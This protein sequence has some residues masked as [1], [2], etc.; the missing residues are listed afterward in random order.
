MCQHHGQK[1][2]KCAFNLVCLSFPSRILVSIS[3]SAGVS[4]VCVQTASFMWVYDSL[5]RYK[6]YTSSNIKSVRSNQELWSQPYCHNFPSG[7]KW[8]S[9]KRKQTMPKKSKVS[10]YGWMLQVLST[11]VYC[12]CCE[13]ELRVII[14]RNLHPLVW[15]CHCPP[16]EYLLTVS[17]SLFLLFVQQTPVQDDNNNK[18]PAD[19]AKGK[20]GKAGKKSNPDEKAKAGAGKKGKKQ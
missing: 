14:C 2:E 17:V 8:Q 18:K 4:R 9:S 7:R 6:F 5:I 11:A 15:R 10:S 19:D 12:S 3:T 13:I 16:H 1:R 20:K